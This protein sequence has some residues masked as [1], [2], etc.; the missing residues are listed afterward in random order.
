MNKTHELKILRV[1]F[2]AVIRE[3]KKFEIRKN[4]RDFKVGDWIR[5]AEWFGGEYTGSATTVRIS[6]ISDYEQKDG[7]VVLG[8]R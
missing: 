5:L 3:D 1:Y 8:F 6:Y 7:Y 2:D 4:D